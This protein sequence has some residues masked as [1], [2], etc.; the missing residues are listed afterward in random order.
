MTQPESRS[1]R[2]RRATDAALKSAPTEIQSKYIKSGVSPALH[3]DG[4]FGG[5]TPNGQLYI[6]FFSEHV[7]IPD[8]AILRRDP[9]GENYRPVE[10]PAK[11]PDLVR[12]VGV[13]VIMTL[14]VARAFRAWLDTRL[15]MVEDLGLEE[16]PTPKEEQ[17]P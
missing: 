2:R 1:E 8:A 16:A 7:R 13:E 5:V 15:K 10:P 3:A 4:I 11:S 9:Q 12:D 14:Q 17:Q 6:A